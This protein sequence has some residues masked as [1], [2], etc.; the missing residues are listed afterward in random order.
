[1]KVIIIGAGIGGLTLALALQQQGIAY[2][3][4]DAAPGNR[5]VGAGIMLGT[6]AMRVY[7][8]LGLADILGSR[9]ALPDRYLIRD[10]NRNILKVIDNKMLLERFHHRSLLI[11]RAALQDELIHAVQA[12]IKWGKKCVQV[13]SSARQVSAQFDDGSMA[14]GDILVGADGIRS[15]VRE[16]CVEKAQY[17]YS[18]QTCWRSIIPIDLPAAE[19][20]ETSEVW[21]GG[22]GLRAS[23][24]QVGP[25]QVY[26]WMTKQMPAGSVF[27]P[28]SAL[29]FIKTALRSFEGYM[30]TV[31]QHLG[32]DTLIHGDLYDIK[33]LRRWYKGRVVLLGDAAH[34]TT[35]NLGQGASQAIEDAYVLAGSLASC[36]AYAKAFDTYQRRR[37]GRAAKIVGM[38]RNLSMLTNLQGRVAVW[39]RNQLMKRIPAVIADRQINFLYGVNLDR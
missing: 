32:A 2:E 23:Y 25:Q 11:H 37:M 12:N 27:T 28:E 8:R 14:S 15:T 10:H 34:A 4:Y 13:A 24:G 39:C 6:N 31:L 7:A 5:A 38:S 26:F 20:T 3:I 18:G 1:M 9:G 19:Q 30:Q 33:P 22:N 21:G 35:P 29:T 17:R 16:Q 36:P